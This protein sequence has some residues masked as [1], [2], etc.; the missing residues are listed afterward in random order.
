MQDFNFLVLLF[1][2]RTR[3]LPL[4]SVGVVHVLTAAVLSCDAP[5]RRLPG[6][7]MVINVLHNEIVCLMLLIR[8]EGDTQA[9]TP[10]GALRLSRFLGFGIRTVIGFSQ[11]VFVSA[12]LFYC[13]TLFVCGLK[14]FLE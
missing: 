13:L 12:A 7:N 1:E 2:Y 4:Q 3:I 9:V 5:C 6:V 10:P 8:A 11:I 14:M